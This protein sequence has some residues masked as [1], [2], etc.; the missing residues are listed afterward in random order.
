MEKLS[1]ENPENIE[2][3]EDA[4][5]SSLGQISQCSQRWLQLGFAAGA[6]LVGG[7]GIER[8][9]GNEAEYASHVSS[10]ENEKSHAERKNEEIEIKKIFGD[11]VVFEIQDGDY[12]AYFERKSVER[13][14]PNLV[15][16][17]AA[18][19][20]RFSN[21]AFTEKYLEYPKGWIAGEV[22]EV[23]YIDSMNIDIE[24]KRKIGGE[25]VNGIIGAPTIFVY[26]NTQSVGN[27]PLIPIKREVVMHELGHAND[28]KTD[29]DLNLKERYDLLLSVYNRISS[30]DSY[31]RDGDRYYENYIDGTQEGLYQGA[32]EYWADICAGYFL[33]PQKFIEKH[34]ADFNLV[35]TYAKKNDPTFDIFNPERGKHP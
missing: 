30:P 14:E 3:K 7:A 13:L 27:E 25:V 20:E 10:S 16:M 22:G 34:L 1:N 23:K 35:D 19:W 6:L 5:E 32:R 9:M 28:W 21:E 31:H 2:S 26:R 17:N 11:S 18:G 12:R 15:N 4:V 33:N 24:S 29:R 8:R